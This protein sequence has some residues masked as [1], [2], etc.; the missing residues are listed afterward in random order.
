MGIGIH[1]IGRGRLKRKT[2]V[3]GKELAFGQLNGC[4]FELKAGHR[5]VCLLIS[6][7]DTI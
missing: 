3:Y 4:G 5:S 7:D 2:L 1:I 6:L